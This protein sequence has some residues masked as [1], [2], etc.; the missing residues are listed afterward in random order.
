[1]FGLHRPALPLRL[2]TVLVLAASCSLPEAK[3]FCATDSDCLSGRTCQAGVCQAPNVC[4]GSACEQGGGSGGSAGSSGTSGKAGAAAGSS[5]TSSKAGAPTGHG[6]NG[7]P[8]TGGSHEAGRAQDESG[9]ESGHGGSR[10]GDPNAELGGAGNAG[11]GPADGGSVSLADG[12]KAGV[13]G[14]TTGDN[15]GGTGNADGIGNASGAGANSGGAGANAGGAAGG[16]SAGVAGNGTAGGN[17][18]GTA[19]NSAGTAGNGSGDPPPFCDPYTVDRECSSGEDP[20]FRPM[21]TRSADAVAVSGSYGGTATGFHLIANRRGTDTVVVS[22]TDANYNWPKFGCFDSVPSPS[23][24]AATMLHDGAPEF[25]VISRCGQL[26]E[27][28]IVDFGTASGWS[29]WTSMQLPWPDSV[30]TDVDASLTL[31]GTTLLY[32]ADRGTVYAR[33]RSGPSDTAPFGSWRVAASGGGAVIAASTRGDGRQ[34]L[35]TL[36]ANGRPLSAIQI[37]N[38]L[39][40]SFGD[41]QDFD[42]ST[43]PPLIE[44]ASPTGQQPSELFAL[45]D[46]GSIWTRQQQ[47]DGGFTPWTPLSLPGPLH[48][49]KMLS[50][51]ALPS[52]PSQQNDAIALAAIEDAVE[53]TVYVRQRWSGVWE[54]DWHAVQ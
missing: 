26:Q 9:G 54:D 36:D 10:E 30:A 46:Q 7:T 17:A 41:W 14:N 22:W 53:T 48:R 38:A 52:I 32:V 51:A 29:P 20:Y 1:M 12:G 49:F 21:L 18:A 8:G 23:R 47:N 4:D 42:S 50:S 45:D 11:E 5:G 43:V 35:F 44:L 33:H 16:N 13:G 3:H 40:A 37:S 28:T 25:F 15:T 19:G 6:G 27:R 2:S 31:D 39:D 34:Q 24:A